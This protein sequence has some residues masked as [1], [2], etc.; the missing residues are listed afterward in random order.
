MVTVY[1][2]LLGRTTL[3]LKGL[4]NE[5]LTEH[6]TPSKATLKSDFDDWGDSMISMALFWPS[7]RTF[8]WTLNTVLS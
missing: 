8:G 3:R 5:T 7:V 6:W 2:D 4:T 1:G